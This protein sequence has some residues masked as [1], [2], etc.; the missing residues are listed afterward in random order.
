MILHN[1]AK[2]LLLKKIVNIKSWTR[3]QFFKKQ[4]KTKTKVA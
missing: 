2:S 1:L 3:H 4:S